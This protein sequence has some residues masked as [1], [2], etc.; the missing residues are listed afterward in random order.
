MIN[1]IRY[2]VSIDRPY[3]P[4]TLV[5]KLDCT[6]FRLKW[7]QYQETLKHAKPGKDDAETVLA[8]WMAGRYFKAK[9]YQSIWQ[10]CLR[11]SLHFRWA[12]K[13]AAIKAHRKRQVLR[14]DVSL[15]SQMSAREGIADVQENGKSRSQKPVMLIDPPCRE[16]VMSFGVARKRGLKEATSKGDS[17]SSRTFV[18]RE[19]V[20]E[21]TRRVAE[22][23]ISHDGDYA[24]A[25]CMATDEPVEDS[26]K[27]DP[28][29]D[30]GTGDPIHEPE[31]GDEGGFEINLD[32][33]T[34]QNTDQIR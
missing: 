16:V 19:A 3:V 6:E 29:V 9:N 13:E 1:T 27:L 34:K 10:L 30:D 26:E 14:R 24:I 2:R 28:I 17:Q 15:L 18:R 20:K 21:Y 7:D 23:N 32:S 8:R 22:V 25:V 5:T 11:G 33:S 12:A 31:Y 4:K